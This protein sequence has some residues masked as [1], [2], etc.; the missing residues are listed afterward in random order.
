MKKKLL[1]LALAAA[2]LSAAV[3]TGCSGKD[4]PV[5]IGN[6][7]VKSEPKNIVVLDDATA[8]IISYLGY[9][10]KIA[11]ISNEVTQTELGAAPAVGT[12]A[13]PDANQIAAL[14]PDLVF[15]DDE[16]SDTAKAALLKKN[17]NLIKLQ[18][19]NSLEALKTNYETLGK[20]LGGKS[21]GL[22]NAQSSYVKLLDELDKQKRSV[23]NSSGAAKPTICYLYTSYNLLRTVSKKSFRFLHHSKGFLRLQALSEV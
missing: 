9:D 17:L 21:T 13:N 18:P 22:K 7:T 5:T 3:L 10:S 14:K 15:A 20:L 12:A 2:A 8:D 1:S 4:F 6:Q 23:S 16:L 19:V 11:G